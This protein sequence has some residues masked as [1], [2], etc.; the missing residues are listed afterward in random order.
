MANREPTA[1]PRVETPLTTARPCTTCDLRR[2]ALAVAVR[3]RALGRTLAQDHE[4]AADIL[5]GL[6]NGLDH[7]AAEALA[8]ADARSWRSDAVSADA[9]VNPSAVESGRTPS[10]HEAA[11]HFLG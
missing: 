9:R 3:C 7:A 10:K 6:A 11:R 5:V 2:M 4:S 1:E 8:T